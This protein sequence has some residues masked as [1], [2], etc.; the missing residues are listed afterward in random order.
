MVNSEREYR[1]A[2]E[3]RAAENEDYPSALD[4]S[5]RDTSHVPAGWTVVNI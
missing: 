5:I 1:K 2:V 3:I 4:T